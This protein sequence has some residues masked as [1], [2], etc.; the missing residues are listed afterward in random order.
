M[1]DGHKP[2]SAPGSQAEGDARTPQYGIPLYTQHVHPHG[3]HT[4]PQHTPGIA[5]GIP[6]ATPPHPRAAYGPPPPLAYT[7]RNAGLLT[8]VGRPLP[9][10]HDFHIAAAILCIATVFCFP[11]LLVNLLFWKSPNEKARWVARASVGL[12]C[13]LTVVVIVVVLAAV[14][15]NNTHPYGVRYP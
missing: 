9:D 5:V 6:A 4:D 7:P 8:P 11:L 2:P 12:F 10:D 14:V 15:V 3:W 13:L 1:D